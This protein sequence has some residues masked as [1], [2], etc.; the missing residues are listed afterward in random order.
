[1]S[2]KAFAAEASDDRQVI[3]AGHLYGLPELE[4]AGVITSRANFESCRAKDSGIVGS[5][6][7]DS[8][9]TLMQR[10]AEIAI[11]YDVIDPI[12]FTF[13][14]MSED[15]EPPLLRLNALSGLPYDAW[16]LIT[17]PRFTAYHS[18]KMEAAQSLADKLA[19]SERRKRL[20]NV[21]PMGFVSR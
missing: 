21:R 2:L 1:M 7:F 5:I 9:K 19:A 13:S 3:V 15:L 20:A 18:E 6:L 4:W 14:E 8:V 10:F 16:P 12:E 17:E 11:K